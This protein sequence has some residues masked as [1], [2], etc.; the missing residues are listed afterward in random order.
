MKNYQGQNQAEVT[1]SR[2]AHVASGE[3]IIPAGALT[4]EI[5]AELTKILGDDLSPYTVGSG[6]EA[7]TR[8][9]E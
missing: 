1:R 3:M 8:H 9:R 4:T 5:M 7:I 2:I 6:S